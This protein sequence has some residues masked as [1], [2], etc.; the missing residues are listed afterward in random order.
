LRV[1]LRLLERPA[2]IVTRE[3]LRR[4]L[5]PDDTYVDFEQGINA[6]VKRL[7]EALGDSAETPRFIETLPKRGYRFIAPINS[8]LPSTPDVNVDEADG[9][10]EVKA[11]FR[12]R[13]HVTTFVL[14][15][16]VIS[17]LV[18]V[19]VLWVA[20][21]QVSLPAIAESALVRLTSNPADLSVTSAH[22]S[23]DG[24]HLAFAD[25]GGLQVRIIDGGKT[26]RLP[27]TEGMNVYGWTPDS[28]GVLAS[29]CDELQCTGWVISLVGQE[30]YRT[31][32]AWP[33]DDPVIVSVRM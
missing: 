20:R 11:R 32:V 7:R 8:P 17:V 15:L 1:L 6:A 9:H 23:P 26:H 5:W 24:R 33:R 3:A 13:R 10:G 27:E 25:P 16:A 14:G 30:R 31:G 18:A 29:H 4:E 21:G 19:V 28:A 12:S 22:I 2:E